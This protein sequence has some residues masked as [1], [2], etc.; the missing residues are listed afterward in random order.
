MNKYWDKCRCVR[1][2]RTALVVPTCGSPGQLAACLFA[3]SGEEAARVY[4]DQWL[5]SKIAAVCVR[6]LAHWLVTDYVVWGLIQIATGWC[7][8]SSTSWLQAG[9]PACLGGCGGNYVRLAQARG[10]SDS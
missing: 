1:L 2:F 8:A 9:R 3:L 4:S 5:S 7:G 10:G 6:A